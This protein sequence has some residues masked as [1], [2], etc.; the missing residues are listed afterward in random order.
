MIIELIIVRTLLVLIAIGNEEACLL[1][2]DFYLGINFYEISA[3]AITTHAV[4]YSICGYLL[5]YWMRE[6]VF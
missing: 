6:V 1:I 5:L 4:L 3:Y 2:I